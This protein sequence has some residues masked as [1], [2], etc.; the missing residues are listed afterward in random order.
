M[1]EQKGG[2]L[3]IKGFFGFSLVS[4]SLFYDGDGSLVFRGGYEKFVSRVF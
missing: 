1:R 2:R 3:T 4:L